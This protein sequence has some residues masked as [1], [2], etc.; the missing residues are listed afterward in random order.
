MMLDHRNEGVRVSYIMPGSVD[1][2]FGGEA[3][4]GSDWK[5][6]P[7]DIADVVV[8]LLADAAANHG[9]QSQKSGLPRPGGKK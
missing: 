7:S 9:K 3:G 4:S 2:E 5:I 8:M 6:A 1:T